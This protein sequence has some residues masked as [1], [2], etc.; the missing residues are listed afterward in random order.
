VN[1]QAFS[2]VAEYRKTTK[3]ML[4]FCPSSQVCLA[5]VLLWGVVN[6]GMIAPAMT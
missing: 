5:R 1:I 4:G 2:Q 6:F 3:A